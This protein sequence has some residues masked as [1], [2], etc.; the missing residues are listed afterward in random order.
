VAYGLKVRGFIFI[1][2]RAVSFR[3]LLVRGGMRLAGIC[4]SATEPGWSP[5]WALCGRLS[6]LLLGRDR[7]G[8]N[9]AV[10]DPGLPTGGSLWQRRSHC[11]DRSA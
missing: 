11:D 7:V 5:G 2:C 9:V 1:Y 4:V 3:A 10:R 6:G 8:Q